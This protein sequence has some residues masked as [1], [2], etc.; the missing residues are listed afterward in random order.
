MSDIVK[1]IDGGRFY[2]WTD[3]DF[4]HQCRMQSR[5]Q[6]DPEFSRFMGALSKRILALRQQVEKARAQGRD[7]GLEEA[8]KVA[9]QTDPDG[10]YSYAFDGPQI[11]ES[12]RS[13]KSGEGG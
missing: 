9:E 10:D 12:V 1:E 5:E 4:Q 6:L 3:E 11:A 8:A 13:L 2:E 7:E